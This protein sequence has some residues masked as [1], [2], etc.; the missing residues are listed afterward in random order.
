MRDSDHFSRVVVA[1]QGQLP[2]STR[3]NPA[4]WTGL[5]GMVRALLAAT[6]EAKIRG[7]SASHFSLQSRGGRCEAC[8]GQG[9]QRISI[10]PL[11]DV[12]RPCP[13]CGGR[14]F[15]ADVLDVTWRGL[16]AADMLDG[17]ASELL[18]VLAG[19]PALQRYLRALVQVGL[20]YVPIGQ[21]AHTLSGGEAQR[22]KLARELARITSLGGEDTLVV[23]DD[24]TVGLHDADT[25]LLMQ[26]LDRMVDAGT[27][28]WLATHHPGLLA[29]AD[30]VVDVAR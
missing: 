1:D 3:S 18:P 21:S 20:G 17:S 6:P 23:M 22:L 26:L 13:V 2:R 29:W 9:V 16:S 12:Y 14:R 7:F 24:P 5:W 30:Q 27:T 10:K 25:A 15:A 11:P 19:H 28:V 4:T 8:G